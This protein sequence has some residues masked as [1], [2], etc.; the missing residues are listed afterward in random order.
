MGAV[1]V[2]AE[3]RLIH[4]H[5]TTPFEA[6]ADA[7]AAMRFLADAGRSLGVDPD[8]IVAA[9]ASA[10]AHL[11]CCTAFGTGEAGERARPAALALS[12]PVL[13]TTPATWQRETAKPAIRRLIELF[14]AAG[15][16]VSPIHRLHPGWPPT[17][18]IHGGRDRTVPPAHS[19]RFAK[20]LARRGVE[21][22]RVVDPDG[23]HEFARFGVRG[24]APFDWRLD[25]IRRFLVA[26][27]ILPAENEE[28]SDDR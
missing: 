13:D 2:A 27:G 22:E 6:V 24:N 21:H 18:M 9:G 12:S 17:L 25:V 28:P 20:A 15:E 11:A 5:G 23:G 4:V 7:R 16:T 14:G 1:G 8:R 3:Y 19:E 10:G 26:R